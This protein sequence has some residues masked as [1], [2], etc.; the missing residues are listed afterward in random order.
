MS[1]RKKHKVIVVGLPKTG[2]STLTVMLRMLNYKVT[3]PNIDYKYRDTAYLDKLYNEY[4]GFQDYPWCFE[5][6]R[7][8]NQEN[9][10]FII[11]K[12]DKE[13]WIKSFYESYGKE[14]DRYLSYPYMK[15]LKEKGNEEKFLNYYD[16]Y[17]KIAGEYARKST[18]KFLT[19]SLKTFEWDDLCE[20][21]DA[22]LPTNIF[23]KRVKK[24]HI[25]KK[26]YKVN[27]NNFKYRIKR[28]IQSLLGKE[29]WNKIIIF[30]RKNNIIN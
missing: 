18:D 21:L 26:N 6:Q 5:W 12:R 25:N 8:L 16:S 29:Y 9:T 28:K 20:F 13:S 15:I 24:P 14:R 7:F 11:L 30:L 4:N 23:G 3:G 1:K 2:T 19:I 22:K 27:K 17:Y 10:K